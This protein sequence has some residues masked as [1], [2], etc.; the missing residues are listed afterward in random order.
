MTTASTLARLA[1][2][3]ALQNNLE[4]V[5]SFCKTLETLNGEYV[6]DL[7][8]FRRHKKSMLQG[9]LWK[10]RTNARQR[11]GEEATQ[12][13]FSQIAKSD[14]VKLA[15][16]QCGYG[17]LLLDICRASLLDASG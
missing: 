13:L 4:G 3:L 15:L 8:I 11:F 14:E 9:F 12:A 5:D 10:L 1:E 7:K 6:R 16:Q 2:L 17:K